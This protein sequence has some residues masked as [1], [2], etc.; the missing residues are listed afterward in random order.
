MQRKKTSLLDPYLELFYDTGTKKARKTFRVPGGRASYQNAIKD[1]FR[2]ISFSP[3]ILNRE[4]LEQTN[5]TCSI[6]TL[7][8][9]LQEQGIQHTR[10]LRRPKLTPSAA[11]A[12]LDFAQRHIQEP[13]SFWK[14][15]IFSDETTIAR[16]DGERGKWVFCRRVSQQGL[17]YIANSAAVNAF[18]GR[19]AAC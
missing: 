1:I 18:L 3:F 16:G 4:L 14:R 5:I 15:W 13:L 6:A 19:K 8:R 7:T 2:S 10:A 12:R 9:Y 17:F 11:R